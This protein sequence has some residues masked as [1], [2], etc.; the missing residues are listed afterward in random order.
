MSLLRAVGRW[1]LRLLVAWTTFG[2]TGS[3]CVTVSKCTTTCGFRADTVPVGWSCQ[4]VQDVEDA[5]MREVQQ[6]KDE[7]IKQ[8]DFRGYQLVVIDAESWM[9]FSRS[10]SGLTYCQ[11]GN[12]IIGNAPPKDNAL[13]HE[14]VHVLQKCTPQG[15]FEDD[16]YHSNWHRDG[17]HDA[18]N[19]A[20]ASLDG[21][22]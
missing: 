14:F 10:V 9:S 16:F 15:P 19:R 3:A 21:G 18:I 7:R 8:C 22:H 1:V 5:I 2:L 6:T 11:N 12:V 4:D 13:A 17:I 20:T